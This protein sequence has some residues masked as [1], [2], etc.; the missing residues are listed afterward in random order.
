MYVRLDRMP[1]FST[2]Q[3]LDINNEFFSENIYF[4]PFNYYEHWARLLWVKHEVDIYDITG[5]KMHLDYPSLCFDENVK[6]D[7]FVHLVVSGFSQM[8][9]ALVLHGLRAAHFGNYTEDNNLRTRITVV[10]PEMKS[11]RPVFESQYQRIEQIYDVD[12]DFR[13]CM[14]ED[15][16]AEIAEWSR[17]KH[18]LMTIAICFS[19]AD[20]A[21]SQA[22]NM[23]LDVYFQPGR[24]SFDLPNILV[25][26]KSLSGIWNMLEERRHEELDD[27][28]YDAKAFRMAP[29]NK[30]HNVHPFGMLVS[31]FYPDDLDDLKPCLVHA[32]YEDTWLFPDKDDSQKATLVHLYEL[33]MK[34]DDAKLMELIDLVRYRWLLQS[35]NVKWANRYQTDSHHILL[36]YLRSM[37]ISHIEDVKL[38]DEFVNVLCS[39]ME[40][41]RWVG[42]RVV[43]GWQQS[44]ITKDEKPLRQDALLLH[45]DITK[46]SEIGSELAKDSSVVRNVL[47][48]DEIYNYVKQICN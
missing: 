21:L 5:Q 37:G 13:D 11:L 20:A 39:D 33:V 29:Y 26:Q 22:L 7:K 41:R 44:P 24:K 43:S 47:I 4:R 36:D 35:E 48:L 12:L 23:P 17:D 40:H 30:Y 32:D 18:R 14:L 45:Y 1:S 42:E 31:N 38:E 19:D 9:M 15:M 10:D 34:R 46:T 25:R 28:L 27:K 8:G 2:L 16:S 6:S 3:R